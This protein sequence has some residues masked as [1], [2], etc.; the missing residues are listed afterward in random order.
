MRNHFRDWTGVQSSHCEYT[1]KDSIFISTRE[2]CAAHH[3]A[4][5]EELWI[6]TVLPSIGKPRRVLREGSMD[7]VRLNNSQEFFDSRV[8]LREIG[9]GRYYMGESIKSYRGCVRII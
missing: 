1:T 4:G 3:E 7:P 9:A 2:V 6:R 5:E 8:I